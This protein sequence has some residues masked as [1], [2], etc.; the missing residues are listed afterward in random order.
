M[1]RV[2]EYILVIG[3]FQG[4]LLFALLCF[5]A[6]SSTASRILGLLCGLMA[7]VFLMPLLQ[8]SPHGALQVLTGVLFCL[9]AAGGGLAYLYCRSALLGTRLTLRDGVV[10]L[11]WL[12]CQL[13]TADLTFG[14]PEVMAGWV[15]GEK[16]AP[17]ARPQAAEYLMFAQALAF[18]GLTARM[19]WRYRGQAGATLA[20]FNPTIFRWML[21]LQVFTI[22]IWIGKALPALSSAPFVYSRAA[23]LLMV[24]LIYVIAITQWRDPQLFRIPHLA[25]EQAAEAKA[26]Q[27]EKEKN[28]ESTPG[29]EAHEGSDGELD[30]ATRAALFAAISNAV[31]ERQLYLNSQLT[32]SRLA[33]ATGFSRHQVSETL[34]RHAGRNFYEFINGYRVAA[35]CEALERQR[36]DTVLDIALACGFSSKS[37]FNTIFKQFTG[38]TPTAYRRQLQARTG[39]TTS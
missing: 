35:V 31:E 18:A 33:D 13:L 21:M 2:E 15:F 28:R 29:D 38:V 5:D 20:D 3:I 11:P 17:T 10:F 22:V 26:K 30:E 8:S 39:D 6:R 16:P 25:S 32:L 14:D 9:P 34:N 36:E 19:I 27:K 4:S 1:S 12:A 7:S 37:T 24:I 23:D